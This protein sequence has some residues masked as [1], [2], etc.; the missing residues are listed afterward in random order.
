MKLL[1]GL[2]GGLAGA[3]S[4]TL[5][6]ELLRKVYSGAP[7]L[8]LLGEEAT[9]KIIRATGHEVPDE[10]T[11]YSTALAGDV[12]AN[13][14]YYGIAAAN[15]KHPIRTATIMGITAGL[16][17]ISLPSKIGLDDQHSA[18]TTEKKLITLGL[19]TI[20]GLIAGIVV[21]AMQKQA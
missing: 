18:A 9:S 7:R 17:A 19:Y 15:A 4:V 20:G 10:K 3:L 2:I 8:D 14:L 11:L 21:R 5:L 13:A 6:H 16:G 1:D 12:A